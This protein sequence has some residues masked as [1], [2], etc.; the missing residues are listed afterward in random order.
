MLNL[1]AVDNGITIY[2]R[3]SIP[4]VPTPLQLAWV[5]SEAPSGKMV[6]V[7][8]SYDCTAQ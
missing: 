8:D 2:S 3:F 7:P 1:P 5:G 6:S 4:D